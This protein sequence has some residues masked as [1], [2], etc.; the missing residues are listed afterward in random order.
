LIIGFDADDTLW[1]NEQYYHETEKKVK[2]L[3][4]PWYRGDDIEEEMFRTEMSNLDLFGYGAKGFI[5]SLIETSLRITENKVS[6]EV[7]GKILG[8]GKELINRPVVLREG[9]REALS[10]LAGAGHRLILVTKGDLLDQMRK[11][12][13]SG[14][15][16]FFDHV[17][18]MSGKKEENY[19]DLVKRLDVNP[20]ECIMVGDSLK[21]DILPVLNLGG[22]AVYIPGGST[23]EHE[24]I[25]DEIVN[26]RF[27]TVEKLEDVVP[28]VM[29][30][31]DKKDSVDLSSLDSLEIYTDGGCLGNPG[32]GGWAYII[33]FPSGEKSNSG[34]EE[35]TTNNK[36]ELTA[37]IKALEYVQYLSA[38]ANVVI[39]TDSQ[40]VRNGITSWIHK[41]VKNGWKTAAGKPVKNKELWVELK[42]LSDK[43]KI[44]W[45][46]VKGHAGNPLNEAC[47]AMVKKEMEGIK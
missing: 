36:M 1:I 21:S 26:E 24:K 22:W 27:F 6:A 12:E 14:L 5:L 17:E 28:V 32:P 11:L 18:I 23:W 29:E 33:S 16:E 7:I 8:L 25:D 2:M 35:H 47:D 45:K 31:E 38:K 40:Y 41:W 34:N 46:W 9:V 42:D 44:T 10:S 13:K 15:R 19:T 20:S 39:H 37:V 30:I 4:S 43:M 3:L